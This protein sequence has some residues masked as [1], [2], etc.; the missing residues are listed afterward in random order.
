[1]ENYDWLEDYYR[2]YPIYSHVKISL[3]EKVE[4][5]LLHPLY[6]ATQKVIDQLIESGNKRI[7]IVMPNDDSDII[8]QLLLKYF[9]N[10]Q[11][12][13]EYAGSVL[14]E[15]VAGDHLRLGKAVVEFLGIDESAK[16]NKI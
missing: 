5:E 7:A 14:D 16:K 11:N 12:V 6:V 4:G 15:V 2:H 1:M 13:P 10:V 9:A 3:F 8:S